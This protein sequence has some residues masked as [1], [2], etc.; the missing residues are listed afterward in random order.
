[1]IS[2]GEAKKILC[3]FLKPLPSSATHILRCLGSVLAEDV[4]SPHDVPFFDN[5]AMDGYALRYS[6]D[7]TTYKITQHIQAGCIPEKLNEGEAA[8]IFTGAPIPE[9]AD[10]VV[11]QEIVTI[12]DNCLVEFSTDA[13][14]PGANVRKKGEQCKKGQLMLKAG[15]I[16]QPP[17]V[18]LLASAGIA[19][20]QV[21]SKPS[22]ALIVSGN[23]LVEPESEI[24]PQGYIYNSNHYTVKAFLQNLGLEVQAYKQVCDEKNLL[25]ECIENFLSDHDVLILTGGIS[26]GEYDY[27]YE[28]L[29]ELNVH[30]LFHKI[31][32]KPGKPMYCG[33]R[34]NKLIFA[35]P[36]NPAS[37]L[38]CLAVY[39]KPSM[40]TMM[41]YK[42]TFCPN[43]HVPI[44]QEFKKKAGISQ[45]LKAK[46]KD[47]MVYILGGQDSFNLMPFAEADAIAE[48]PE[49]L[50]FVE[51]K[52]IISVYYL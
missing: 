2:V 10:T 8:R 32:Q 36:G 18:A 39:V 19:H 16:L 3:N 17:H 44:A 27:V 30:T 22:V 42:N 43:A 51:E 15:T 34:D 31:K 26:V 28:I 25:R 12:K 20:I 24:L 40:L 5:S 29:Q 45:F 7:I 1:M 50:S 35:L 38:T 11:P 23:E 41:G 33:Y 37:V 9:F 13:V 21:Y 6:P 46:I 47:S 14:K 48:I 52:T 4:C 49:E